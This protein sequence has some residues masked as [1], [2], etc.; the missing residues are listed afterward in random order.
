MHL[1]CNFV[2]LIC[3]LR[4]IPGASLQNSSLYK[5]T[6]HNNSW[7]VPT[8]SATTTPKILSTSSYTSYTSMK[9][10]SGSLMPRA[11]ADSSLQDL[12]VIVAG[13]LTAGLVFIFL[14]GVLIYH[15]VKNKKKRQKEQNYTPPE[16]FSTRL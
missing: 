1:Y 15:C 2:Y 9:S 7:N 10:G 3:N 6:V 4:Q 8:T 12:P 11:S 16:I 13:S 5:S 14:L